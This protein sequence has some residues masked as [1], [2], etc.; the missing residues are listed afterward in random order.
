MVQRGVS[1]FASNELTKLLGAEVS[2]GNINLGFLNRI[3]LE[4]VRLKDE[5][6][7]EMLS[8]ARVSA[9]YDI[10]PL[11]KGKIDIGSAQL[12]G[13]NAHLNKETP[14]I[15]LRINSLLVRRGNVTYDVLSEAEKPGTF[16]AN[17]LQL[18]NLR[19]NISLKALR[20]DTLNASIRQLSMVE[21]NSGFTL[22]K[23]DF[24]IISS[25]QHTVIDNFDIQLPNTTLLIDTINVRYDS[26]AALN[27]FADNAHF[28]VH[29]KELSTICISP[30]SR[31]TAI[32]FASME[33][34]IFKGSPIQLKAISEVS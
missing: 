22:N 15:D 12:F 11:F 9:A 20:N 8:V 27:H 31:L 28:S 18:N 34:P 14:D 26:I 25:N 21:A 4:N 24:R 2:I 6:G 32:T 29:L 23:L 10:A 5:Q 3:I 17:H 13:F 33:M 7:A 30:V 16:N 1:S 19:A